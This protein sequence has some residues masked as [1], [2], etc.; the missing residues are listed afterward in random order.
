MLQ[1]SLINLLLAE[2]LYTFLSVE[3]TNKQKPHSIAIVWGG[4][5][6]QLRMLILLIIIYS[7]YT[8]WL[9]LGDTHVK[10]LTIVFWLAQE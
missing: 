8:K 7:L 6:R 10:E 1:F 4:S 9:E 5:S 2:F 3:K